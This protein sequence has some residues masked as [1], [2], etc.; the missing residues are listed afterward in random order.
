[1][2]IGDL[3]NH[4]PFWEG[5]EDP[6]FDKG[7]VIKLYSKQIHGMKGFAVVVL[8]S[9]GITRTYPSDELRVISSPDKDIK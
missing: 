6:C 4:Y 7:I 2:K 8:E 3:V 1:M 5:P 9:N